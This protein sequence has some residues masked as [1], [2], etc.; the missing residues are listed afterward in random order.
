MAT[1]EQGVAS[2]RRTVVVAV[3]TMALCLFLVSQKPSSDSE[4][5]V[6]RSSFLA[7]ASG[8]SMNH[9]KR[10]ELAGNDRSVD[11]VLD[12]AEE[13]AEDRLLAGLEEKIRAKLVNENAV[14]AQ[15]LLFVNRSQIEAEVINNM[16][17]RKF[18]KLV[19]KITDEMGT[20]NHGLDAMH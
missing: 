13:E 10:S 7:K 6:T 14:Q 18:K 19:S 5:V 1:G 12:K 9:G 11:D 3:C 8:Q 15:P 17:E 20:I 16:K 4:L 2:A